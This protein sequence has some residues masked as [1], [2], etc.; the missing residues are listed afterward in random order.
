MKVVSFSFFCSFETVCD[1]SFFT[2]RTASGFLSAVVGWGG[3][4]SFL[5]ICWSAGSAGSFVD[6]ADSSLGAGGGG[7]DETEM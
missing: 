5:S 7:A 2:S 6:A 1:L 4:G 3:G